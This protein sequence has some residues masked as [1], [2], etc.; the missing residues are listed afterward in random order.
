MSDF[1]Q[2]NGGQKN[3]INHSRS[4]STR[5]FDFLRRWDVSLYFSSARHHPSE[6]G[7]LSLQQLLDAQHFKSWMISAVPGRGKTRIAKL[8]FH[9]YQLARPIDS[10]TCIRL[11]YFGVTNNSGCSSTSKCPWSAVKITS[12]SCQLLFFSTQSVMTFT[13]LSPDFTAPIELSMLS[14]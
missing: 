2:K 9:R 7:A 8:V 14:S 4:I 6:P 3:G 12:D 5:V 13:A 1:W 11:S 10:T